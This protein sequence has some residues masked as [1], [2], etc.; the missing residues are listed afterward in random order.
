MVITGWRDRRLNFFSTKLPNLIRTLTGYGNHFGQHHLT[1]GTEGSKNKIRS[2]HF[3]H[4]QHLQLFFDDDDDDDVVLPASA[5]FCCT[6]CSSFDWLL[7]F[8]SRFALTHYSVWTEIPDR[9]LFEVVADVAEIPAA[10]FQQLLAWPL[11][12]CFFVISCISLISFIK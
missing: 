12:C 8:E 3:A 7:P 5:T 11:C 1:S 2:A 10:Q 4:A 9:S 6:H